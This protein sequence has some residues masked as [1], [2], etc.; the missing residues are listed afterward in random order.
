MC[1]TPICNA[2]AWRQ[3]EAVVAALIEL[4]PSYSRLRL[5]RQWGGIV[6][7]SPDTSPIIGKTPIDNFYISCGWGTGG[8][9]AI[10]AGGDTL[11]HTIVND[12]PHPLIEA[13][14]LSRFSRG[15]LV[16]EGAAAGV[17]H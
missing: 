7:I 12:A 2:G 17:D 10:P 5:M 3:R 16:D 15:A 14:A 9:K 8:Y 13:F 1:I 11:A 6:D 4:F